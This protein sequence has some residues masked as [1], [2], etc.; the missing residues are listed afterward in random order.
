MSVRWNIEKKY[1]FNLNIIY[2]DMDVDISKEITKG[3]RSKSI[4]PIAKLEVGGV[5]RREREEGG[6]EGREE[7]NRAEVFIYIYINI[8]IH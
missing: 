6:R 1:S 4:T 2:R 5:E 8:K 3:G 7:R